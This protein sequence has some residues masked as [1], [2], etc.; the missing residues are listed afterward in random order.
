MR[1]SDVLCKE[2]QRLCG[3]PGR[4]INIFISTFNM[5]KYI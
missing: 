1:T 2:A 3:F 5:N 4:Y